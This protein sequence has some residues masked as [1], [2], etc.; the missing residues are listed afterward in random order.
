MEHNKTYHSLELNSKTPPFIVEGPITKEQFVRYEM[1]EGLIA[2][3]QPDKQREALKNVL[4]LP[5]SR[6]IIARDHQTIVGYSIFLYPD[7]IERWSEANLSNLL[8]LGAI[9]VS[10]KYRGY[11]IAK[12]LLKVAMADDAMEDYII[13]TTEYYWHWDLRG[14]GLSIWEY[15]DIMQKVM[16]VGGLECYATDDPE[17]CSH[18]AN[19]LMARIGERVDAESIHEFNRIRFKYKYMF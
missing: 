10:A 18:P 6:L 5:E 17:I 12:H 9:E 3:R 13:I 15:R 1:D 16:N 11:G 7:E 8:E 4:E 19:C 2:F 14:A